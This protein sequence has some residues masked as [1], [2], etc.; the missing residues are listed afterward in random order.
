MSAMEAKYKKYYKQMWETKCA[1]F[2]AHARFSKLESRASSAVILLTFSLL[3]IS[4]FKAAAF[5]DLSEKM[6]KGGDLFLIALSI[7][8]L[9]IEL[10]IK[11]QRYSEIAKEFH[12]SGVEISHIYDKYFFSINNEPKNDN[13][14]I[15]IINLYHEKI[16]EKEINHKYIDYQKL[17]SQ[18]PEE[19]NISKIKYPFY[20]IYVSCKNFTESGGI[21]FIAGWGSLIISIYIISSFALNFNLT[22]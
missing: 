2:N 19:Y 13:E 16:S 4:L 8:L 22:K 15:S 11:G 18:H 20:F 10:Y 1:R 7:A 3:A 14:I 12:K 9:L 21:Y 17:K 5:F 6:Q